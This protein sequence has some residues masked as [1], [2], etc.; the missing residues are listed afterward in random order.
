MEKINTN[1]NSSHSNFRKG[2]SDYHDGENVT[3]HLGNDDYKN[4]ANLP[5]YSKDES[6]DRLSGKTAYGNEDLEE[7]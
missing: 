1:V 2:L 3:H 5:D 4:G 7:C 6:N